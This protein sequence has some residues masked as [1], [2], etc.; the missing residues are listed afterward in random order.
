ME[1]LPAFLF[2]IFSYTFVK[3]LNLIYDLL[4]LIGMKKPSLQTNTSIKLSILVQELG[5]CRYRHVPLLHGGNNHLNQSH[6]GTPPRF[7]LLVKWR[8][9]EEGDD[10]DRHGDGRDAETPAPADVVLGVNDDG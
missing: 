8:A 10:G 5:V 3:N 4:E 7:E 9:H 1:I 2:H 6:Q